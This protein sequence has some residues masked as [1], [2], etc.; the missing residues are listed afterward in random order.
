MRQLLI[1]E[2]LSNELWDL[3]KVVHVALFG[4]KVSWEK[5]PSY[6]LNKKVICTKLF[7]TVKS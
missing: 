5:L 2:K 3:T 7:K 4:I 1:C 6:D